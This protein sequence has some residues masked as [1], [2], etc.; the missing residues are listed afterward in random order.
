MRSVILG[1][2]GLLLL[3]ATPVADAALAP[4]FGASW[5]YAAKF[6][7]GHSDGHESS[8]GV[9]RGNYNSVINIQAIKSNTLLAFRATA[10]R[11]DLELEW[12]VPSITSQRF[13][14]DSDEGVG[15]NCYDIKRVLGVEEQRGFVEG[16]VN[17][18]SSSQLN[19][20]SVVTGEGDYDGDFDVLT[21]MQLLEARESSIGW[22]SI[23]YQ[24]AQ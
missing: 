6:I 4:S 5:R 23:E 14:L 20:T 21:V 7:C 19:V 11:S 24:A 15:L 1:I 13:D 16:F 8:G 2:F 3:G 22:Q 10:L 12:G 18:Y 9:I 17:V